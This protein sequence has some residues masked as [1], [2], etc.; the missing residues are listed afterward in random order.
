MKD[1]KIA[2]AKKPIDVIPDVEGEEEEEEEAGGRDEESVGESR[3]GEFIVDDSGAIPRSLKKQRLCSRETWR[4]LGKSMLGGLKMN[5]IPGIC[6]LVLEAVIIICFYFCEP[7]S[8][9]YTWISDFKQKWGY[10]YSAAATS[11]F[12]G[13][14]PW[15]IGLL[16]KEVP[17]KPG[18]AFATLCLFLVQWAAIGCVVDTLYKVQGMLFGDIVDVKTVAIKVV[19]DQFLYNPLLGVWLAFWPFHWRNHAFSCRSCASVLSPSF[20]FITVMTQL[21]TTWIIWIPSVSVVYCL[22]P[23]L[24]VPVFNIILCFSNLIMLFVVRAAAGNK[25]QAQAQAAKKTEAMTAQEFSEP[26]IK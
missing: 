8:P 25:A 22:S 10:L 18:L 3:E 6:L 16:T 24:Q 19:V 1:E 5:A 20:V 15:F 17:R 7:C 12:G 4:T 14:F 2:L 26:F 13:L 9:V 21:F 11:I 23:A